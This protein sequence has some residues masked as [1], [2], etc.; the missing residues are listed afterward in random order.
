[1]HTGKQN[2]HTVCIQVGIV[3]F[4]LGIYCIFVGESQIYTYITYFQ[5]SSFKALHRKNTQYL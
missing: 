3:S 1:M 5:A 2:Q 4:P